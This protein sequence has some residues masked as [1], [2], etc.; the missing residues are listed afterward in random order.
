VSFSDLR[1]KPKNLNLYQIKFNNIQIDLFLV[2][3]LSWTIKKCP[4]TVV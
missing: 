1:R 2:H 3:G 4:L